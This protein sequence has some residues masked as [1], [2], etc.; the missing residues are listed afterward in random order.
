MGCTPSKA[1]DA[2]DNNEAAA[3]ANAATRPKKRIKAEAVFGGH[4][5]AGY[6]MQMCQK[7]DA[8]KELIWERLKDF[9]VMETLDE[10]QRADVLDVMYPCEYKEGQEIMKQGADADNMYVIEHGSFQVLFNDSI[11]DDFKVP[12][13]PSKPAAGVKMYFGELAIMNSA[14][15]SATIRASGASKCWALTRDAYNFICMNG[16]EAKS[17]VINQFL[18]GVELLKNLE[19]GK[20]EKLAQALAVKSYD[21]GE[22]IIKQGD[23]GDAFYMVFAGEVKCTLADAEGATKFLRN[24]NTGECF[25]EKA[26]LQ[27]DVRSATVTSCGCDCLVVSRADFNE[28]LGSMSEQLHEM[29]CIRTLDRVPVLK[30]L[31]ERTRQRVVASMASVEFEAGAEII[32]QNDP[33]ETFFII[34]TGKVDVMDLNGALVNTMEEGAYFG[35]GALMNEAKGE[36][37]ERTATC[38]ASK[39]GKVQCRTLTKEEFQL[40]VS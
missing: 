4:A 8:D 26:L 31:N 7:S 14:Q 5:N 20:L 19:A 15:R 28:L 24:L 12:E 13:M 29:S 10:K 32:R 6:E 33:G 21:D 38:S 37:A 34:V 18:G 25:G 17:A 23:Y 16:A 39:S 1:D 27:D 3:T 22:V 40:Y 2:G 35:E 30:G 36:K 9:V 11:K